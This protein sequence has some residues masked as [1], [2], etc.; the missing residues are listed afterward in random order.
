MAKFIH[1]EFANGGYPIEVN[2]DHIE[3]IH[4]PLNGDADP[5]TMIRLASGEKI[6]VKQSLADIKLLIRQSELP[7][8]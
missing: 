4:V 6:G 8:P 1:V 3:M 2:L 5:P 7:R